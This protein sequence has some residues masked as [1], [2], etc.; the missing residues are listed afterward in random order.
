MDCRVNP[1]ND[2]ADPYLQRKNQCRALNGPQ[3]ASLGADDYGGGPRAATDSA[4]T[5]IALA[6]A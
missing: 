4:R 3:P 5:G 2:D 1:G 6:A